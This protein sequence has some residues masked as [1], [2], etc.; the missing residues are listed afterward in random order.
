MH[1]NKNKKTFFGRTCLVC[2]IS[3]LGLS[4]VALAKSPHAETLAKKLVALRMEV[5]SLANQVAQAQTAKNDQRRALQQHRSQLEIA[6]SQQHTRQKI[7]NQTQSKLLGTQA[8][9]KDQSLKMVAPAK[10]I[11]TALRTHIETSL[12]YKQTQRLRA[13]VKA[14]QFLYQTP[15]KPFEALHLAWQLIE[16]ESALNASFEFNT[17]VLTIEGERYFVDTARIGMALLYF[18]T[19]DGHFGWLKQTTNAYVPEFFTDTAITEQLDLLFENIRT[20]K[21]HFP[22]RLPFILPS[23]ETP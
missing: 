4:H 9:T 3:L 23:G 5:E 15:G 21:T 12:P 17:D 8:A 14:E 2:L 20:Q 13:L 22:Q 19:Q 11:L 16:D 1:I 18:R 7:L 10:K 6:L